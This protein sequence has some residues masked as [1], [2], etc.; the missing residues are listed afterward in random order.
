MLFTHNVEAEILARQ[1]LKRSLAPADVAR[2]VLF[3]AS[4]D[5]QAITNQSFIIDGGWV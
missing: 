5:S 2:L 1:A 4:V 3:L